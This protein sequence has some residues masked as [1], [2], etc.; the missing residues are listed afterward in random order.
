MSC[1]SIA[2]LG[3]TFPFNTTIIGSD[4]VAVN[5]TRDVTYKV[6]AGNDDEEILSGLMDKAFDERAGLCY[7][8]FDC[9]TANGF[10]N[11]EVYRIVVSTTVESIELI[12]TYSFTCLGTGTLSVV[13][14]EGVSHF[15]S[16]SMFELK[17][18]KLAADN[19]LVF[20]NEDKTM[21]YFRLEAAYAIIQSAL[22]TRGLTD[23][24]ISTWNR[25]EEFQLDIATYWYAKDSGWGA[26]T[27]EEKDWTTVFNR[28]KELEAVAVISNDGDVLLGS[29]GP[30]ADVVNLLDINYD[31]GI[32][33]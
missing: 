10:S 30:V 12:Q 15:T 8:E 27:F 20:G 25:G 1:S 33:H 14:E 26:K 3:K 28:V 6:Y 11:G 31:L 13:S 21:L 18:A 5:P 32:S 16:T 22:I 23:V 17:L 9:T 19:N 2:I 24:Q 4:A 7:A 29:K